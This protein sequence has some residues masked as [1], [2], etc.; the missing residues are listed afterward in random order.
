MLRSYIKKVYHW[1]PYIFEPF[2]F[3]NNARAWKWQ[4]IEG[5]EALEGELQAFVAWPRI[6]LLLWA[7]LDKI[8]SLYFSSL[9][10]K[11]YGF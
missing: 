8:F 11:Y 6:V 9:S 4:P 10:T 2:L 1:F 5:Q 3:L 7:I